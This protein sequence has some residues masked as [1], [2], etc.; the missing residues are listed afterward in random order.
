MPDT[1]TKTL[2]EILQE[3]A[4]I[5]PKVV[6]VRALAVGG[7]IRIKKPLHVIHSNMMAEWN[8][9]RTD[10]A[11]IQAALQEAIEANEWEWTMKS[12]K[13]MPVMAVM[14]TSGTQSYRAFNDEPA[15]ALAKAFLDALKS[16]T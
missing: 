1:D 11:I 14:W 7:Y 5:A 13:D 4:K 6:E 2:P 15:T 8:I 3:I 9:G 12:G 16:T 10:R